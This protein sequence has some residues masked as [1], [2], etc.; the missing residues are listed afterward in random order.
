MITLSENAIGK[1]VELG[2][3]GKCLRIY[4]QGGGC[5]GYSYGFKF[6]AYKDSD[7]IIGKENA[8]CVIDPRSAPLLVGSEI[9][10][11]DAL[12]GAGFVVKNPNATGN[13]GCGTSFSV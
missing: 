1:I 12:T 9:D 7:Y 2:E 13:C 5:S 8:I 6:D 4:V 3:V 11:V 10:Y